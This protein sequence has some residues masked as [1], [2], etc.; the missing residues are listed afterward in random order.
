M[1]TEP[2]VQNVHAHCVQCN[3][4]WARNWY[5]RSPNVQAVYCVVVKG[6]RDFVHSNDQIM[7]VRALATL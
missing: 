7:P 1:C 6:R 4:Q 3:V 2:T 5:L